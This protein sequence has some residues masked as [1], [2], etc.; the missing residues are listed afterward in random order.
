MSSF[1]F[2]ILSR[3]LMNWTYNNLSPL[4]ITPRHEEIITGVGKHKRGGLATYRLRHTYGV[5]PGDDDVLTLVA[6]ATVT[7]PIGVELGVAAARFRASWYPF[8]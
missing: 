3:L 2:F 8:W 1:F 7:G 4:I 5:V 6:S